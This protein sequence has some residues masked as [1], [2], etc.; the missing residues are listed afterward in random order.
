MIVQL[1]EKQ[2]IWLAD[3]IE[4][5]RERAKEEWKATNAFATLDEAFDGGFKEA[6]DFAV[7]DEFLEFLARVKSMLD[8][9]RQ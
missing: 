5:A 1:T 2:E 7:S 3:M 4:E 6:M 8:N 9:S